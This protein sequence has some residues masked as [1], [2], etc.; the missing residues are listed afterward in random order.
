MRLEAR[1]PLMLSLMMLVYQ[2]VPLEVI[3][4]EGFVGTDVRRKQ[5]MDA[6]VARMFRRAAQGGTYA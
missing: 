3:T 1:S 6:Y 4:R 5:L 2:D